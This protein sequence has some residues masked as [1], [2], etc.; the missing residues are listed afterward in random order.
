MS[1]SRNMFNL[2]LF[3]CCSANT[4]ARSTTSAKLIRDNLAAPYLQGAEEA[5][6]SVSSDDKLLSGRR[7]DSLLHVYATDGNHVLSID[8]PGMLVDAVWAPYNGSI[9]CTIRSHYSQTRNVLV[10]SVTGHIVAGNIMVSPEYL[11]VS[12]D[13]VI[14]LTDS[15]DGIFQSTD[16]GMTWNQVIKLSNQVRNQAVKVFTSEQLADIWVIEHGENW[17]VCIY[18]VLH[19]NSNAIQSRRNLVLPLDAGV[20]NGRLIFDGYTNVYIVSEFNNKVVYCVSVDGL[21]FDVL[22]SLRRRITSVAVDK[23]RTTMF[24]GQNSGYVS[25][26]ALQFG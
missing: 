18:T 24:V 19:N 25:V 20:D 5:A 23:K 14:Y 21:Y 6:L 8:L 7:A 11:S 3:A 12:S 26:Y 22:I 10:M 1:Q 16:S 4:K 2:S 13:N 17:N 9:I 15:T